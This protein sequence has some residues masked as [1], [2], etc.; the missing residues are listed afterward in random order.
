MI[1]ISAVLLTGCNYNDDTPDIPSFSF[2]QNSSNSQRPTSSVGSLQINSS[3]TQEPADTSTDEPSDSSAPETSSPEESSVPVSTVQDTY[4]MVLTHDP[5]NE[6]TLKISGDTIT[7]TGSAYDS[8][9]IDVYV[10]PHN[11]AAVDFDLNGGRFT[12]EIRLTNFSNDR[13]SVNFE[14]MNGYTDIVDFGINGNGFVVCDLSDN[15]ALNRK[16]VEKAIVQPQNQVAEYIVKGGNPKEI[17]KVMKEIQTISDQICAGLDNDY[18][19]LRAISRWVSANIYYDYPA[20]NNDIPAETLSLKYMLDRHS[21]VCG[22]YSNMTSALCAVQGIKCW[23]VH[24][25]A[26]TTGKN[27]AFDDDSEYHEWNFA[28]IDGRIVWVDSGWNSKCYLYSDNSY[29]NGGI[30]YRYFDI[31]EEYLAANHK[32]NYAEYRDYLALIQ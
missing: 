18:D 21:S 16:A 4:T 5:R 26:L 11:A 22:G 1:L 8:P 13:I 3:S 20:F 12:A 19:K 7:V 29:D 9:V 32:A 30:T 24:G 23:N 31:S 17:K 15:V 10:S 2:S 27:F 6:K 28:E 25:A 14:Y